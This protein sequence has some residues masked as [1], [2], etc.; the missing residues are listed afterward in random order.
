MP[1]RLAHGVDE[2][3]DFARHV[4]VV[5][6]LQPA[7]MEGVRAFV[8]ERIALHAVDAEDADAPRVQVRTK[9]ANHA[10]TFLLVLVAQL[11]GNAMMGMP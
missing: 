6:R 1:G 9:S 7:A 4:V 2:W 3:E 11:V 10:L 8:G 5:L